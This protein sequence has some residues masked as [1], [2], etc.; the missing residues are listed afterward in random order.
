MCNNNNSWNNIEKVYVQQTGSGENA[1]AYVNTLNMYQVFCVWHGKEILDQR[2]WYNVSGEY[3][4]EDLGL[5]YILNKGAN[6]LYL[7]KGKG[8]EQNRLE[9]TFSSVW[10]KILWA[11]LY[12]N[13]DS[14]ENE[15]KMIIKG[16]TINDD[17][18]YSKE[19]WAE[20][21]NYINDITNSSEFSGKE[22][23]TNND[24][25]EYELLKKEGV[26]NFKIQVGHEEYDYKEVTGN[27]NTY[28]DNIK[29]VYDSDKGIIK[30]SINKNLEGAND[31][32]ITWKKK[33]L[34]AKYRLLYRYNSQRLLVVT[35]TYEEDYPMEISLKNNTYDLRVEKV[36][37]SV[38]HNG[39][40]KFLGL[41][42]NLFDLNGDGRFDINDRAEANNAMVDNILTDDEVKKRWNTLLSEY[43]KING[44]TNASE[45]SRQM[46]RYG[47]GVRYFSD[48]RDRYGFSTATTNYK[49]NVPVD[50]S[51]G[52]IV[53]YSIIIENKGNT[54]VSVKKLYDNYDKDK[55]EY[56]GYEMLNRNAKIYNCCV[57]N[58]NAGQ[59]IIKVGDEKYIREECWIINL[60]FKVL[61]SGDNSISNE[62]K[63][64]SDDLVDSEENVI[65]VD[66]KYLTDKD[67][68]KVKSEPNISMQKYIYQVNG[69][70]LG[71][72]QTN[73]L[74][75]KNS[76]G[77]YNL[78]SIPYENASVSGKK[79]TNPVNIEFG[80]VVTYRIH[81]Y[82]NG[83]TS[84]ENITLKDY[85]NKNFDVTIEEI[86]LYNGEN[87][88]VSKVLMNG[89]NHDLSVDEINE[90][91]ELTINDLFVGIGN[92]K[93]IYLEIKMKFNSK[94]ATQTD[95][96]NTAIIEV[97]NNMTTYRTADIDIVQFKTY[98]V[99]LEKYVT[100]VGTSINLDPSTERVN[101]PYYKQNNFSKNSNPVKLEVGDTVTYTIKLTNLGEGAVKNLVIEETPETGLE[102]VSCTKVT[103]DDAKFTY[104]GTINPN[105]R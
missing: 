11:Y 104:T 14:N 27:P 59:L 20:M 30:I 54:Y 70:S 63:I 105:G 6:A 77:E 32:K 47:E 66:S 55:L 99:S 53:T 21:E 75:R 92:Q 18:N 28:K 44:E 52:D 7:D 36:V 97:E 50:V 1:S 95:M 37:Y 2:G 102:Y 74:N 57:E 33:I 10:Q 48:L 67:Y 82:N 91:Q 73:L 89:E 42:E 79:I 17:Y 90:L 5:G 9:Y 71:N 16:N 93:E 3:E 15:F 34:K 4:T 98:S 8:A 85:W 58:N 87:A 80:D 81:V 64:N 60:K 78:E 40:K 56:V 72:D 45:L 65:N 88:S 76:Y 38:E 26:D 101:H 13:R 23:G 43:K 12:N 83:K 31:I 103:I 46:K 24:C 41:D 49:K 84:V 25:Y 86:K 96:I 51:N 68:I 100:K 62:V 69:K 22:K 19:K 35:E 61:S 29:C 39:T 94:P